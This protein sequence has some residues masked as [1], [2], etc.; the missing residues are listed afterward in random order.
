MTLFFPQ[1]EMAVI[2]CQGQRDESQDYHS[3]V[4]ACITFGPHHSQWGLVK[5]VINAANHRL[6][7]CDRRLGRTLIEIYIYFS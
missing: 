4:M 5:E 1:T 6:H 7:S 2:C 3:T